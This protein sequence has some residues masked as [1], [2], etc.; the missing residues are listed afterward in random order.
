MVSVSFPHNKTLQSRTQ[1]KTDISYLTVRERKRTLRIP[2]IAK[3]GA[4][5]LILKSWFPWLPRETGSTGMNSKRHRL[6]LKLPWM[7][8][9]SDRFPFNPTGE[10]KHIPGNMGVDQKV[11]YMK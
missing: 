1:L 6:L 5:F 9:P 8:F 7:Y 3:A 4:I 10:N 11:L 2:G